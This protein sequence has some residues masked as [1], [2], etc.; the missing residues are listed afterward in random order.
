MRLK[1]GTLADKL[2][3]HVDGSDKKQRVHRIIAYS[4]DNQ[5]KYEQSLINHTSKV[6]FEYN[7]GQYTI[8][9]IL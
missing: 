6:L 7:D 8:G 1:K 5:A 2:K 9:H 4:K 3:N